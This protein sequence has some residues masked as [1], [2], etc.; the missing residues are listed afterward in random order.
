MEQQQQQQ[1][2]PPGAETN[3]TRSASTTSVGGREQAVVRCFNGFLDQISQSL[4]CDQ[5]GPTTIPVFSLDQFRRALEAPA[6][7]IIAELLSV[8]DKIL[9]YELENEATRAASRNPEVRDVIDGCWLRHDTVAWL[10]INLA[11]AVSRVCVA[12]AGSDHARSYPRGRFHDL[13]CMVRLWSRESNS[14][15]VRCLTC[16]KRCKSFVV[17]CSHEL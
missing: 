10:R 11:A 6:L 4:K 17:G 1:P 9:E 14:Y 16:R 13:P 7:K 5:F 8:K 2:T 12:A 15:A 3:N